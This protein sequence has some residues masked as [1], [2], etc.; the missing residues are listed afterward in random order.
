MANKKKNFV[1]Q[2]KVKK[3]MDNSDFIMLLGERANGKSYCVKSILLSECYKNDKEF[4]YLR[5][6]ELDIKDSLCVSYFGDCPVAE[7]TDGEY[8]CIDVFRKGIYFAN[9]D[10]ESGKI[11]RGKKIGY[12]HCLSGAEHYKSLS[13]PKVDF[14]DFEEFISVDGNYLFNEP[15]KLQHYVSTIFRHRKGKVFLVGNLI[16]RICPYY[17]EW[18]ISKIMAKAVE[19]SVNYCKIDETVIAVYL[20]DSLNFNSGMFFGNIAKN[21]TK[22]EYETHSVPHLPHSPYKYK[23]LYS[24]VLQYNEFKFLCS[25][26]QEHEHAN[27]IT[28]YVQPKTTEI[29]KKTRVI[30]NI[31]STD[32]YNIMSFA[33]LTPNEKQII[34][35]LLQDRVCY[36]DNLTGTEFINILKYFK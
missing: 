28:W 34:N 27:N 32:P 36:S 1:Q 11:K 29:H 21:I 30:S 31:F 2:P 12:C 22:G 33:G 9:I 17:R 26:L 15:D 18:G 23:T 14:I 10:D 5:R 6:F 19:G 24:F 35:L 4:I 13:F 7:I 16:S 25:L 3:I 8:T 20:T